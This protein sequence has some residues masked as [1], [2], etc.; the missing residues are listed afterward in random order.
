VE[1]ESWRVAGAHPSEAVALDNLG[2]A[3]KGLEMVDAARQS[4]RQAL[5]IL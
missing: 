4:W 2:A 1:R 5:A 3:Q